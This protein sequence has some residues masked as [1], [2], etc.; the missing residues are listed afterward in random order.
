MALKSRRL[1]KRSSQ[2]R[3]CLKSLGVPVGS[4]GGCLT[5]SWDLNGLQD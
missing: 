4:E 5:F 3:I 2:P 1:S